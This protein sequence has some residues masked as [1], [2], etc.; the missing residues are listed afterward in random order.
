MT[1]QTFLRALPI[2]TLLLI[3][4]ANAATKSISAEV[5]KETENQRFWQAEVECN[6]SD[7]KRF[8]QKDVDADQWCL[9]TSLTTCFATKLTAAQKTCSNDYQQLISGGAASPVTEEKQVETVSEPVKNLPEDAELE[10]PD[11][12]DEAY[13]YNSLRKEKTGLEEERIK[14]QQEKLSLKRREIELQKRELQ[15][16]SN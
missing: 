3:G 10:I 2:T 8:I 13:N 6:N 9:S 7:E 16:E 4:S 1:N 5:F 12:S 15:L 14:I 11:E